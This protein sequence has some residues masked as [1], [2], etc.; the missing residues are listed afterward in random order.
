MRA[1]AGHAQGHARRR[2][3]ETIPGVEVAI[4]PDAVSRR[5]VGPLGGRATL[6][7]EDQ[8][9]LGEDAGLRLRSR[10]RL[11]RLP[12]PAVAL[13]VAVAGTT[14]QRARAAETTHPLLAVAETLHLG[15]EAAL[16]LVTAEKV[17]RP[18]IVA[19]TT[20][21]GTV[22]G[23]IRL[24]QAVVVP[25]LLAIAVETLLRPVTV[26]GIVPPTTVAGTTRP[27]G[28][29]VGP[30]HHVIAEGTSRR[31]V[32][33]ALLH[34]GVTETVHHARL[35]TVLLRP[36]VGGKRKD[37]VIRCCFMLDKCTC[38]SLWR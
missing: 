4:H 32:G 30:V 20:R 19:E 18:V 25:V 34:Q 10:G 7:V 33:T 37:L 28:T 35:A 21:L 12:R 38:F 15:A 31:A 23:M 16:R 11:R 17:L 36:P 22:A 1:D 24:P 6:L 29:V 27:P 13:L 9:L 3:V 26:V 8:R 2:T 5:S 14:H